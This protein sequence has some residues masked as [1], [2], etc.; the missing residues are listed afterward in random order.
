MTS[1]GAITL[2]TK[3]RSS[4]KASRA[5]RPTFGSQRY[6]FSGCLYEI[7]AR[8]RARST[9]PVPPADGRQPAANGPNNPPPGPILTKG[10]LA[11]VRAARAAARAP[12]A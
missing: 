9:R 5:S 11:P 7:P 4:G 2:A 12:S 1:A 8:R 6:S 10:A 3:G